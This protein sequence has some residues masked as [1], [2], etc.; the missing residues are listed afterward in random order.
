MYFKS[1]FLMSPGS[2]SFL[3]SL[4]DMSFTETQ[5]KLKVKNLAWKVLWTT[6]AKEKKIGI[7]ISDQRYFF[8]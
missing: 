7:F 3:K 8:I 4:Q 2:L 1:Y 6:R 5:F